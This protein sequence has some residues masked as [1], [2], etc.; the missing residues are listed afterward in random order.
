[1]INHAFKEFFMWASI[2]NVAL[3][4]FSFA[5]YVFFRKYMVQYAKIFIKLS[6]DKIEK[7]YFKSMIFFKIL[8]VVFFVVPYFALLIIK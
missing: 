5:L 2:L 4:I 7:I 3:Y 8:V 6:D 1:M